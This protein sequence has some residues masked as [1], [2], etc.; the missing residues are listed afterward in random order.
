MKCYGMDFQY[1]CLLY[2]DNDWVKRDI[3]LPLPSFLHIDDSH[4]FSRVLSL[5]QNLTKEWISP[6]TFNK[7]SKERSYFM[8]MLNLLLLWNS[9]KQSFNYDKIRKVEKITRYI[10]DNYA[11]KVKLQDLAD[12]VQLSQS[13]LQVIFKE[14]TGSSPIEF[15]LTVRINMSKELMKEGYHNIGEISELVGFNDA[16]YFSR[17]FKKMEGVTPTE[18]RSIASSQRQFV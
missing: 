6:A 14:I 4:L 11:K 13:Y 12:Y 16:F 10:L 17:C 9:S 15:L 1:S 5:F 18:Y 8:E 2:E 3:P 7:V